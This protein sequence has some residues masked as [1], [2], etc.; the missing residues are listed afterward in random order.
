MGEAGFPNAA[1]ESIV[2][3]MI[4]AI[5]EHAKSLSAIDGAI[6]DGDHGINMAKG[7][8]LCAERLT[9]SPGGFTDA[10]GTLGDVL[11]TEIGGAMGPLYGTLF[12]EMAAAGRKEEIITVDIVGRMLAGACAAV[13]ELG[14]AKVGDKT[15]VDVLAPA[16]DA[17]SRSMAGGAVFTE[18]LAAMASAAE[19]GKESTR[20]LVA[21]VGRA[22]RLGERSRGVLDAGASSCALLLVTMAHAMAGLLTGARPPS[23]R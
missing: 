15:M 6:G 19:Q 8:T 14:G 12:E 18:C 17:Y 4:K 22:S 11:V 1:G 10:L 2:R 3:A 13:I 9:V 7:F 23:P 20:G 21:K 5:Q 16:A